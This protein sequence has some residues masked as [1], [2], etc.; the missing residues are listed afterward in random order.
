MIILITGSTGLARNISDTFTSTPF[1]GGMNIVNEARIED[2]MLWED[3]EWQEYDVFINNAFGAPFDQCDLLEKSF[4]AYRHDMKKIIIN[5]S[6]RA[7]QPNISKG[8][9]YAAAKAALNHMSNNYTYNSD[10]KCKITTMNLGLIN[11]ELPSLSYQSISNAIW[12]LA[13]S[14]PDI[15]IPEVTMQAHANYNEVQSDKETLRDM[16]RFTK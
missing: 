14:Y 1:A 9:K 12:Y 10:K 2:L 11:H 16:E 4:N 7:S 5:I 3:W 13:T 6:S 8:Y 15:E